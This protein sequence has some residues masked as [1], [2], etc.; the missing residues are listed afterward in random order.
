VFVWDRREWVQVLASYNRAFD[1]VGPTAG[2]T[3]RVSMAGDGTT[4]PSHQPARVGASVHSGWIPTLRIDSGDDVADIV[5][6]LN[7]AHH[8]MLVG[9]ASML[10]GAV[11]GRLRIAPRFVFSASEVLTD[12]T[13]A[14]AAQ[15]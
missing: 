3:H 10:R 6:R 15:A 8:Q 1:W 14:L 2:L 11:A 7:T 4:N 5:A 12:A 9:Y 13:G